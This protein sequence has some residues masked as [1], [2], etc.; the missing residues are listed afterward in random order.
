[1]L[2]GSRVILLFLNCVI[3][4]FSLHINCNKLQSVF[5]A[6]LRYAVVISANDFPMRVSVHVLYFPDNNVYSPTI[7]HWQS[8]TVCAIESICVA[9]ENYSHVCTVNARP[10]KF[11][12]SHR[13]VNS[14]VRKE[15]LRD[16]MTLNLC[17]ALERSTR[18]C[19]VEDLVSSPLFVFFS[20]EISMRRFGRRMQNV[21]ASISCKWF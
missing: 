3:K 2:K 12:H 15:R 14:M 19:L 13:G 8:Q 17:P 18:K 20:L 10:W 21:K 9:C 6:T 11:A 16:R 1:M 7:S 5:H 4:W